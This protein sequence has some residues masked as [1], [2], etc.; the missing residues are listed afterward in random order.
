MPQ[1]LTNL[2]TAAV[3]FSYDSATR[4]IKNRRAP[5]ARL[6]PTDAAAAARACACVF[7]RVFLCERLRRG[8][9]PGP[10]P[11]A[12]TRVRGRRAGSSTLCRCSGPSSPAWWP[13]SQPTCT[14]M[15]PVTALESVAFPWT[16]VS[17]STGCFSFD[18]LFLGHCFL[19]RLCGACAAP[20]ADAYRGSCEATRSGSD[21]VRV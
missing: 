1:V 19:F 7:R 21:D 9:R 17:L 8:G 4:T 11:A 16:M 13:V 10:P 5:T 2:E 14:Y 15:P 20:K 6:P 12:L 3:V 18:R